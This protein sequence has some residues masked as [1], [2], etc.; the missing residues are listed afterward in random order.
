VV[1]VH[2]FGVLLQIVNLLADGGIRMDDSIDVTIEYFL[3][4]C[5]SFSLSRRRRSVFKRQTVAQALGDLFSDKNLVAFGP[6][7]SL[8]PTNSFDE[9]SFGIVDSANDFRDDGRLPE[10][11]RSL[12]VV[13]LSEAYQVAVEFVP[14]MIP[15]GSP[16]SAD[17][18]VRE[19]LF[20]PASHHR[21]CGTCW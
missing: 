12:C 2:P 14:G 16:S 6:L 19:G 9:S 17:D 20:L 11:V 18:I 1:P 13:V 3:D 4:L 21:G 15:I 5:L 10:P 7:L 8:L